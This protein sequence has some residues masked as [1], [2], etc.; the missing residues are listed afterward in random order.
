VG[1]LRSLLSPVAFGAH[2]LVQDAQGRVLLVRHN[3][4]DGWALPGGGVGRAEPP[5]SA[6]LRELKEEVGLLRSAEPELFGLY[7]RRLGWA[8]NVIALYRVRNAELDFK[9]NFEIREITFAD[10][11]SPPAGTNPGARRRLAELAG[12][13][14]PALYW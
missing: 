14:K 13:A 2:A 5:A 6:L 4:Y 7:S 11:A 1:S 8:T 10:P 12:G 3:Y 9:P